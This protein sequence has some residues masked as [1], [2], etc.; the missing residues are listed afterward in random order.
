MNNILTLDL[1]TTTGWAMY[2][3]STDL[4][5]SGSIS[6]KSDRFSG[7]GMRFLRFTKWLEELNQL[8]PINEIYYEEVRRHVGT[9]AA[10]TYG[11]F[12]SHLTSFAEL[13]KIPYEGIAVGTIKKYATGKGNAGKQA[14]IDYTKSKGHNPTDDNEADALAIMY[15][16]L[17]R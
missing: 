9:T 3:S 5:T 2:N 7:G 14:M 8:Q 15:L 17:N 4:I 1:G 16:K 6:F 13:H 11:G 12:W 10:H